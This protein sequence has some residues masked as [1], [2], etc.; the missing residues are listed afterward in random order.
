ML[1]DLAANREL[2]L[3]PGEMELPLFVMNV[4]EGCAKERSIQD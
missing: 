4:F 1:S 3:T 2:V